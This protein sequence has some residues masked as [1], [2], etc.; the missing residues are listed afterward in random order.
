[1]GAILAQ[2]NDENKETVIAYASR[3]LRGAEKN[4][5]ITDLECLAIMWGVQ[6]FHKFLIE[7]RFRI[8]T[9]HAAL[10]GM[11]N[12]KIPKGR[13]ATWVMELQQYDFEV[14][15]RGG[16]ENK[17]ADAMSIL[18]FEENIENLNEKVLRSE[19]S[20]IN[21]IGLSEKVSKPGKMKRI[22]GKEN[23]IWCE[24]A[25][26]KNRE[27]QEIRA[28]HDKETILLRLDEDTEKRVKKRLN[29]RNKPKVIIIST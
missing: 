24:V 6:H 22:F 21:T 2:M 18:K 27:Q 16:K 15:H 29:I 8:I 4:Y 12:M 26:Y 19:E 3:S 17:N 1:L 23:E 14:I 28:F 10:K 5:P 7:R 20:N 25:I 13:R 11:V 9:D